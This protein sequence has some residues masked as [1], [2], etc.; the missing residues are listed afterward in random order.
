MLDGG[1]SMHSKE[2]HHCRRRR[3]W[4]HLQFGRDL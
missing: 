3:H 4:C 1:I 2:L